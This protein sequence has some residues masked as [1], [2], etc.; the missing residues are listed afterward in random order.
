MTYL[1]LALVPE[2][3]QITPSGTRVDMRCEAQGFYYFLYWYPSARELPSASVLDPMYRPY[4]SFFLLSALPFTLPMPGS[5]ENPNLA[6]GLGAVA[7]DNPGIYTLEFKSPE[8]TNINLLGIAR[9]YPAIHKLEKGKEIKLRMNLSAGEKVLL[10]LLSSD[11]KEI[12]TLRILSPKGRDITPKSANRTENKFL[13]VPF[14]APSDGEHIFILKAKTQ[15]SYIL[16]AEN[17]SKILGAK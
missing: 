16:L 17:L 6:V 2:A 13:V 10:I 11:K 15:G 9:P 1:L 12:A 5:P 3:Y 4:K 7:V 14:V 8:T